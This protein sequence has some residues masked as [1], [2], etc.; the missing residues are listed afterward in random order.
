MDFEEITKLIGCVEFPIAACGIMFYQNS[1][2]QET[3]SSIAAT[4][5]IMT[6]KIKEIETKLNKEEN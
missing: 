3:L 2:K 4:M 5:S 1:K 6:D